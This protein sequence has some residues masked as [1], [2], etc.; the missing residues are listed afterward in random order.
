MRRIL[1]CFI[2]A[3]LVV[4]QACGGDSSAGDSDDDSSSDEADVAVDSITVEIDGLTFDALAA[5]PEDGEL[6]LLLHGFPQTSLTF[7]AQVAALGDAGY[8]AVAPDQRGYSPGARPAE[9]EEYAIDNL[10]DDV[11][12]TAD[13]LGADQ[14]HLVGHNWGGMVAWHV[15]AVEPDRLESLSVLS[16]PHPE[17]YAAWLNDL[18]N[19]RS[20]E[21]TMNEY[22]DYL[23]LG[24]AEDQLVANDA[25]LLRSLWATSGLSEESQER[26][27]EALGTPEAMT[28]ALNW[29]RAVDVTILEELDPVTTPTLYVWSAGDVFVTRDM[30]EATEDPVDGPYC[31]EELDVG[32]WIPE[33]ASQDVSALL[34]DHFDGNSC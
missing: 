21:E 32:H 20:T 4:L 5:G 6:V 18:G 33:E 24:G 14:F 1:S 9:V 11:V 31:F 7:E 29:F 19:L 10:V 23:A 25:A 15:A 16:T 27:V 26:Y 13:A 28:A 2:I 22:L 30:A 3:A 8:R 34:L 17:A 12:G